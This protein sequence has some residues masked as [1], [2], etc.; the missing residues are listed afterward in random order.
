MYIHIHIAYVC[1]SKA[2]FSSTASGSHND[3][4]IGL[5]PVVHRVAVVLDAFDV[6]SF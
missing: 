5:R 3:D 6:L 2:I 4:T 1:E